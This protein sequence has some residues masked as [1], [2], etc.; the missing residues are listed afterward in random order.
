M[1]WFDPRALGRA[2]RSRVGAPLVVGATIAT[3]AGLSVLVT[4]GFAQSPDESARA[5]MSAERLG[6]VPVCTQRKG[7]NASKGD[8]NIRLRA[9]CAKGQSPLKLALWPVQRRRG[10]AGK[11]GPQG[12]AGPQGGQG[13]QGPAGPAGARG[14]QGEQG[15]GASRTGGTAG[16]Q[17]PRRPSTAWPLCTW[18]EAPGSR[19]ASPSTRPSSAHRPERPRAATSA[20]R[21]RPQ[22]EP[23]RISIGAAVISDQSTDAAFYPRLLIHRHPSPAAD[24]PLN[25]C[26]YVDGAGTLTGLD[27]IGRVASL[28]EALDAMRTPLDM[29]VGGIAR[30]RQHS[31]LQLNRRRDLG[32]SRIRDRHGVLRRGG[33]LLVR[34]SVA[35]RYPRAVRATQGACFQRAPCRSAQP[36][37]SSSQHCLRS[38]D[39]CRSVT[40]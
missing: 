17:R 6:F 33:D 1:A 23:C 22:Q 15:P 19:H 38:R 34:G 39:R 2:A 31:A 20:S 32:A 26:E 7:N 11:Q 13:P 24:A 37:S 30:L 35:G 3:L 29:A 40:A 27:Q 16:Q 14:P 21:A 4:G 36:G 10:P 9:F 8:L 18:L 12:P 5:V 25:S 28:G